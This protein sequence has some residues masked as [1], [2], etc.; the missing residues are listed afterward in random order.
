MY[1]SC[2]MRLGSLSNMT[3]SVNVTRWCIHCRLFY[4]TTDPRH[5][6]ITFAYGNAYLKVLLRY[7]LTVIVDLSLEDGV[8]LELDKSFGNGRPPFGVF[9]VILTYL[10]NLLW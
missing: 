8:Y 9:D 3:E 5:T 7:L 4:M 6:S 10:D 2:L 1:H